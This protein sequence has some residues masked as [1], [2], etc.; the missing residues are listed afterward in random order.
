[1]QTQHN[2]L[3]VYVIIFFAAMGGML[4]GYD[5]GIINSAFLFI[6]QD[7]PM[8][9][10]QMSL[11]GGSVLFGGAFA[12]LIGGVI[13]DIIGRKNT[14][15]LAA[16]IFMISVLMI[17]F[18]SN[19]VMLLL[20]RLVQ[21]TAVGFISVT[22]PIYLTESVS[23]NIRGF[24]VT[25]FQL[26]L[27]AGILIA[28][29]VG[30]LLESTGNWR[31]MFFTALVPGGI[32]FVGCFFLSKSPRWLLMNGKENEA[33][34]VLEETVGEQEANQEIKE[35]K[36]VIKK[37]SLEKI[38][39]ISILTTKHYM[40][41]ILIVFSIAI[42]AQLTG[43]NSFLEFSAILLK[44]EGLNSNYISIVG[45]VAITAI[46]FVATIIAVVIADK[47]ERKFTIMI[48]TFLVGVTL[49]ITA[50]ALWILPVSLLQ[51]WILLVGLVVFI[52]FFA[53]GP[54]AYVWVIMSELLPT[55]IRSKALAVALFLNSMMSAIL[56]SVFLPATQH[57]GDSS[58]FFICGG[59][60]FLYSFIVYRFVPKTSG[61]SLEDIEKE[62][63]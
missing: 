29:Y 24:A 31:A 26:F 9:S 14:L 46:N 54:G 21:G 32:F 5:I 49:L 2:K 63:I 36:A 48:C 45:G 3:R 53:L 28:N 10:F 25:C 16:L 4:Y 12:I 44:S 17:D 23:G 57:L 39:F 18:S 8:N 34:K 41:P 55:Q 60:T 35:I 7:I 1:M 13:A 43:I 6:H 37:G 52:F 40:T 38:S 27:T 30:L 22:V 56:A 61:R 50:V 59:F 20:S 11:L 51:G 62:F 58:M 42:L 15:I 33:K 19:Y 47:I